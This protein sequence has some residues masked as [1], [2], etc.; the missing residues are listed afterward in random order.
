MFSRCLNRP[1]PTVISANPPALARA[2][3]LGVTRILC[4][5]PFLTFCLCA[6]DSS[7]LRVCADPN[8]LP[9]SNQAREG[10]ENRLAELVARDI[11]RQLEYSWWPERKNF[12][13][14]SLN[15]G[16][17][18]VVIGVPATLPS[19]AATKPYY[20]SSYVLISRQD[21]H[22]AISSLNDPRLDPL[23]IGIHIVGDDYAPPARILAARG[24][25]ANLVAFS[26]YGKDG[27]PNPPARIVDAV[28]RRDVD[29]AIA[30]GPLAGYFARRAGLVI[31][32]VTPTASL[33]IPFVYDIAAA[34]RKSDPVLRDAIDH[35]LARHCLQIQSLLRDYG[36]PQLPEGNQSCEPSLPDSASSR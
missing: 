7:P 5:L 34:V 15:A 30:W 1:G 3:Q 20:R 28:S 19:V 12:I 36:V 21:S 8:N 32:P 13:D 35:S 18:D 17:C 27:E 24:L 9:F 22:P 29:I 23:R 25:S 10:F 4:A 11:G 31:T 26:L 33:G 16:R 6:A 14:Q 2:P